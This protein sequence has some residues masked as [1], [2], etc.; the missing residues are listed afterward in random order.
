M[1]RL[2]LDPRPSAVEVVAVLDPSEKFVFDGLVN[3]LSVDDPD[4]VRRIDR[5]GRPRRRLRSTLAILLWTAAPF[6]LVFGGWTGLF[7]A[8]VAVGYGA[9]LFT[10][11]YGRADRSPWSSSHRRPGATSL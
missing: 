5:I 11:R 8:V 10:R 2:S 1:L 6:C 7:M 9:R 4:F 3:R